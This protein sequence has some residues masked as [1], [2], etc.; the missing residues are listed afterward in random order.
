M[1]TQ[2]ISIER[3][4]WKALKIL[5]YIATACAGLAFFLFVVL[6]PVFSMKTPPLWFVFLCGA[7][8]LPSLAAVAVGHIMER[9]TVCGAC[10]N[11]VSP[12]SLVCPACH[13][14][15]G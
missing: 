11:R 7:P 10:R 8:L 3:G 9:A 13:C 5:G 1:S 4:G 14:R 15:L 6:L 2:R 12:E